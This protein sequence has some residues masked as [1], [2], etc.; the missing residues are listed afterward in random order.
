MVTLPGWLDM[1]SREMPPETFLMILGI[2]ITGA[3]LTN[4]I[5]VSPSHLALTGTRRSRYSLPFCKG[6]NGRSQ[7]PGAR[8]HGSAS[9]LQFGPL[10]FCPGLS[11]LRQGYD[12]NI[13]Q[14]SCEN[15]HMKYMLFLRLFTPDSVEKFKRH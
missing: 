4:S 3:I 6:I 7:P 12:S 10:V 13:L 8:L 14:M 2:Y 5:Y 11:S 9:G 15:I 1:P